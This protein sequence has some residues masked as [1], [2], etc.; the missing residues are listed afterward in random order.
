MRK[1]QFAGVALLSLSLSMLASGAAAEDMTSTADAAENF[2][3]EASGLELLTTENATI[4]RTADGVAISLKLITPEAG[5]YTYPDTIKQ[6]RQAQP[7]AFTG[8]A[9]VF[10]HP[11]LCATPH[12]CGPG[13]FNDQV[14]FGIYN[15]AGTTNQISQASGGDLQLNAAS[16]GY[17]MLG[18][19]IRDGQPQVAGMPPEVVTFPLENPMGAEI[20]AAIAPHGQ[21]DPSRLPG[22][23]Y[24]PT[25]DPT[26]GCWWVAIFNAPESATASVAQ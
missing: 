12:Q 18:G 25:G 5:T 3:T 11:E 9:F 21:L 15:F 7:E 10:N 17:V 8:W 22:E 13:D 14:R 23:L 1:I 2:P 6:K 16:D 20:H 19:E 26:C 24:S 4:E